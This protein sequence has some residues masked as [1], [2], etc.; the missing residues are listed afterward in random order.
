[1]SIQYQDKNRTGPYSSSFKSASILQGKVQT[2]RSK[3]SYTMK[4]TLGS[5]IL[6]LLFDNTI[7]EIHPVQYK[8]G[9]SII[10]EVECLHLWLR[11]T[12]IRWASFS[13]FLISHLGSPLHKSNLRLTGT[14][15]PVRSKRG[16]TQ[17]LWSV[18]RTLCRPW[19]LCLRPTF[20]LPHP[21]QPTSQ[22]T[23][24][25]EQGQGYT[26]RLIKITSGVASTV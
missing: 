17:G 4:Y 19:T 12:S 7:C 1:M 18:S 9:M 14:P 15:G 3:K 16:E 5:I 6:Y 13:V 20:L 25:E 26:R 2:F 22:D 8:R 23:D 24:P 11:V 10:K 21:R